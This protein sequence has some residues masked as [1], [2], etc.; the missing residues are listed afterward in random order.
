MFGKKSWGFVL[1]NK[2][3]KKRVDDRGS[4]ERMNIH[5]CS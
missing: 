5:P 2:A 1:R 3:K 4:P